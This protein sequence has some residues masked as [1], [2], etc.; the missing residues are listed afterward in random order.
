MSFGRHGLLGFESYFVML[1]DESHC[2]PKDRNRLVEHSTCLGRHQPARWS[3]NRIVTREGR[4]PKLERK[5]GRGKS[6]LMKG[7]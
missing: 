7:I 1:L 4:V 5:V 2:V 3:H 6:R